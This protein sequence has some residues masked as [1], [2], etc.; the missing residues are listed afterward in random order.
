M[1]SSNAELFKTTHACAGPSMPLHS[2]FERAR[3]VDLDL[4]LRTFAPEV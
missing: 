1:V 2:C 3:V 4:L